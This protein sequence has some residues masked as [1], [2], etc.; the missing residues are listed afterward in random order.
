MKEVLWNHLL[1]W[2]V[3]RSKIYLNGYILYRLHLFQYFAQILIIRI[4]VTLPISYHKLAL[5]FIHPK[6]SLAKNP[7]SPLI[8]Y[9]PQLYKLPKKYKTYIEEEETVFNYLHQQE[10]VL[11]GL[12]LWILLPCIEAIIWAFEG[13]SW[14]SLV[15]PFCPPP[16]P[17]PPALFAVRSAGMLECDD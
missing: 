15:L 10:D 11:L 9:W 4:T 7:L 13:W 3:R 8:N 5:I 17:P 12:W 16:P 6:S 14:S 1:K 2:V